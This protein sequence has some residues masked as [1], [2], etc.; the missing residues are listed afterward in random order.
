MYEQLLVGLYAGCTSR[1]GKGVYV[2]ILQ[3]FTSEC[4]LSLSSSSPREVVVNP[5]YQLINHYC[6]LR[7]RCFTFPSRQSS[8]RNFPTFIQQNGLQDFSLFFL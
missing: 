5:Q 6:G 7:H 2:L 1:F 8:A 4:N 3:T